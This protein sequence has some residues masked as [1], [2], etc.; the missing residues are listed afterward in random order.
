MS[1]VRKIMIDKQKFINMFADM[2]VYGK[3]DIDNDEL[4]HE[5]RLSEDFTK[6]TRQSLDQVLQMNGDVLLEGPLWHPG[7]SGKMYFNAR[8][9][10]RSQEGYL[11]VTS[12]S[13]SDVDVQ[14]IRNDRLGIS[15]TFQYCVKIFLNYKI[16]NEF[17]GFSDEKQSVLDP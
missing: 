11:D 8:C 3:R 9:H 16:F 14:N 7:M 17:G 5:I 12:W 13:P 15:I 10:S 1:A 2:Q 4:I 6:A